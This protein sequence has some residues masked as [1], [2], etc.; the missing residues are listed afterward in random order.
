M[1]KSDTR[2]VIEKTKA[3]LELFV[4]CYSREVVVVLDSSLPTG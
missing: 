4:N 3:S 2:D 1:R